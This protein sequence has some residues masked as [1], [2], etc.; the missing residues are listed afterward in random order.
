MT[1]ER[2]EAGRLRHPV[3]LTRDGPQHP[4]KAVPAIGLEGVSKVFGG[5]AALADVNFSVRRG[6]VH[7]LVGE[8][9]AGKS[10]LIKIF[11]GIHHPDTGRVLVAG[12]ERRI[13]SP[14]DAANLGI[15][16]LHQHFDLVPDL[17]VRENLVLTT[18]YP[19]GLLGRIKWRDLDL[20]VSAA[21]TRAGISP[22]LK[23]PVRELNTPQQQLVALSRVLLQDPDVIF[24]DEPTASLGEADTSHMLHVIK[25]QR[26]AGKTI[27]F[28]SH[29]LDEVLDVADSITVLRDGRVET[30][31]PREAVT[32]RDLVA[33]LGGVA[34]EEI[35][36]HSAVARPATPR[37]EVRAIAS[38]PDHQP[39]SLAVWPGEV[40][41]IAGLVGS[42]RSHFASLVAGRIPLTVGDILLDGKA[43]RLRGVR[44]ALRHG[45]ALLPETRTEALV[46]EFSIAD[47]I[48]LGHLQ[49]YCWHGL[50]IQRRR[51]EQAASVLVERLAIKGSKEDDEVQLLSGGNQQKVLL[52]RV[53]ELHPQVLLLDEPTAGIDIATKQFIYGLTRDLAADG[54]AIIFIS[55]E[56]EEVSLVAD[57]ILVW[58]NGGWITELPGGTPRARIVNKLFQESGRDLGQRPETQAQVV[59]DRAHE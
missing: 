27:V 9:G 11:A 7:A 32:H 2:E 3:E 55:S 22:R 16:F 44:D 10:T 59:G 51:V 30:T 50:V 4:E 42:G 34:D 25:D 37:L 47:N 8:N 26:Q 6:S 46:A 15:G 1:P 23:T 36:A 18:G 48:T 52:A 39:V 28:I 31:T 38:R 13:H 57:R 54:L 21:L 19:R 40:L 49:P 24:L 35:T 53:L 33:L 29:R 14:R 41:G 58:R 45:I 12:E 17:A 56:L 5:Q 20:K 43:I